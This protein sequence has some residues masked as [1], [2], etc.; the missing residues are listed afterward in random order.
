[1]TF[2]R[3]RLRPVRRLPKEHPCP[4]VSPSASTT[5]GHR[6]RSARRPV[7]AAAFDRAADTAPLE[8]VADILVQSGTEGE[9]LARQQTR[10]LREVTRWLTQQAADH[11]Q[12]AA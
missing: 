5:N 11:R 8:V 10:V 12:A 4:R 9:Q 2:Q 6:T 3:R 1:M 7:G